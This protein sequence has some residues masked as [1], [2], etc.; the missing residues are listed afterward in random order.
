MAKVKNVP[1]LVRRAEEGIVEGLRC[2]GIDATVQHS[3]V[4]QTKL[5]RLGVYA[6]Q[7]AAMKHSERQSLV[8]RI[9]EKVLSPE[10][11][12]RIS[13][14]LTLTPR[15]QK[16]IGGESPLTTPAKIAPKRPFRRSG[17]TAVVAE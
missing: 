3:P 14:I 8:W 16:G 10:E 2:V 9:V 4:P 6:P 7:F 1:E 17:K 12:M 15:E 13:M 11:Q 5:Y